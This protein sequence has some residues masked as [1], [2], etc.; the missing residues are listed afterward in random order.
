ML[1][2]LQNMDNIN[3]NIVIKE[4][5]KG[6]ALVIMNKKCYNE[7]MVLANHLQD[8]S[9]YKIVP[10]N[11]DIYT[12]RELRVDEKTRKMSYQKRI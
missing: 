2:E 10:Q 4:A 6:G 8:T 11:S 12:M 3:N 5:D 7:K 1:Y 9:T